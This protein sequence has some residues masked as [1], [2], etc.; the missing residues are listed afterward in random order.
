[1]NPIFR[2]KLVNKQWKFFGKSIKQT[3]N[4]LPSGE[5]VNSDR[6]KFSDY[7]VFLLLGRI[8]FLAEISVLKILTVESFFFMIIEP[9]LSGASKRV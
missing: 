4:C 7:A 1:M 2:A 6:V 3:T 9:V 5:L 8:Y